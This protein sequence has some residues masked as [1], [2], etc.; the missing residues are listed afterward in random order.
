VISHHPLLEAVGL[1]KRFAGRRTARART[2]GHVNAV[3]GVSLTVN[4]GETL[5]IVGDSGCGKSTLLR[6]L[7]RLIEPTSGKV[8]FDGKEITGLSQKQLRPIRREIQIV[9]QDPYLSLNGRKTVGQ[10]VG[11]PFRIHGAPGG[12][13]DEVRALLQRVGLNPERYN[14]FPHEF[15]GGERQRIGIARALALHPQV[16][17]LDEPVSALDVSVQAQV[18]N[19]L[20][21]L[22]REFGLTFIFVSHDLSVIRQMADRVAVMNAGRIVELAESETLFEKPQHP[23]TVALLD[24]VPRRLGSVGARAIERPAGGDRDQRP[25]R[26]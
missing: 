16:V 5:G 25:A 22:K 14:R 26:S 7:L 6:L 17:A 3:D 10:I 13:L 4:A 1:S 2:H 15:S 21:D 20:R 18:L 8:L 9:F 23:H 12:Q 24:A 19:L 11:A